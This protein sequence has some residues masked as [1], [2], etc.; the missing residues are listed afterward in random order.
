MAC[1]FISHS[2]RDSEQADSLQAWLHGQGFAERSSTLTS[3][4]GYHPAQIGSV[5]FTG[6]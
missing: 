5:R 6:S 1:V 4:A 2:N 3:T